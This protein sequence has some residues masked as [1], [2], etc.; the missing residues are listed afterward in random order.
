MRRNSLVYSHTIRWKSDLEKGALVSNF[1]RRQW[2][3]SNNDEDWNIYWAS[4]HTV[5]N[6]FNPEH[7]YRLHDRQLINH[8]P[9]HYELTRKDLMVKNIKRYAKELAKEGLSVPLFVPTTYLL[10]ADYSLFVEEFR[11]RPYTWIMK[12]TSKAR[13]IGIF[14]V[15]KLSQIKKWANNKWA[16][17]SARD[18]YVI[19]R[20]INNPLLVGGKKFDLRLYALV[21]SYRPLRVYLYREGFCRFTTQRYTNDTSNLD[22]LYV[23]LTNVSI[24]T[25]ASDYNEKHGGKWTLRNFRLYIEGIHGIQRANQVFEDIE[26]I[27]LLSLKSVQG[28]IINDKHCFECYGYDIIVDDDLKC[29]L[30]EVNASPSLSATTHD[31]RIMKHKLIN[32][33]FRVVTPNNDQVDIKDRSLSSKMAKQRIGQFE[34]MYDEVG[35]S[36]FAV[37]PTSYNDYVTNGQ[38]RR[39]IIGGSMNTAKWR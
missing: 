37:N 20:Y 29:W 1:E 3:R 8:F 16:N 31:D 22:N 4:V 35:S 9:N 21:T 30:V 18:N 11:R 32:D 17:S 27:I 12:P 38:N 34:L 36:Q 28:V 23:H 24:Q 19:S 13:G 25:K 15:N 5:K 2:L 14:I 39:N 33:I 6:L 26:R 10:P 7:G